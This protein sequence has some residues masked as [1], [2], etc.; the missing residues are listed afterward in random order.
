MR[1]KRALPCRTPRAAARETLA[2]ALNA[3]VDTL[4]RSNVSV[5]GAIYVKT[6]GKRLIAAF[7][8]ETQD[9]NNK[10]FWYSYA[11]KVDQTMDLVP[12]PEH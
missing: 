2:N 10:W 12:R 3:D 6:D 9:P 11:L 8:K 4:S 5:D 7:K 1:T